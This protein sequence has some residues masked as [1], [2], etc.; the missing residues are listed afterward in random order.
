MAGWQVYRSVFWSR[1][2]QCWRRL[3]AGF[4]RGGIRRRRNNR[5]L[6]HQLRLRHFQFLYSSFAQLRVYPF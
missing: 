2:W 3:D 1:G 5:C 6:Q 4:I